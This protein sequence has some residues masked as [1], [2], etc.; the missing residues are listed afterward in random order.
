MVMSLIAA[1]VLRRP[2][3]PATFRKNDLWCVNVPK[4]IRPTYRYMKTVM[5]LLQQA[6]NRLDSRY[7]LRGE[8]KSEIY[9]KLR[10]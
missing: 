1:R 2:N 9:W 3:T 7:V 4:P 8:K 10:Y 6:K 5:E